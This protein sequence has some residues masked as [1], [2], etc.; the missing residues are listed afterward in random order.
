MDWQANEGFIGM[1]YLGTVEN[2]ER[3]NLSMSEWLILG[4][5]VSLFI[6]FNVAEAGPSYRYE[7]GEC[8][9]I[10]TLG[11]KVQITGV[12]IEKCGFQAAKAS[13]SEW[14]VVAGKCHKVYVYVSSSNPSWE[15]RKVQSNEQHSLEDCGYDMAAP[16]RQAVYYEK[17]SNRCRKKMIY[18]ST[19]GWKTLKSSP[20]NL[21][22]VKKYATSNAWIA[23]WPPRP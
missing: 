15:L 8:K 2:N 13:H 23:A 16:K 4:L 22:S 14:D 6:S 19:K 10:K 1:K 11:G 20:I 17:T 21:W 18:S 9:M 3:Q 7:E 12:G 5:L